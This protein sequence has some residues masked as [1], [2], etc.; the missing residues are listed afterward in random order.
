MGFLFFPLVFMSLQT[1]V[2]F[3]SNL[4]LPSVYF[5]VLAQSKPK[6]FWD[7][8]LWSQYLSREINTRSSVFGGI[9][10]A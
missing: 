2:D 3:L 1:S 5:G 8:L 6:Q 9:R 7:V 4:V 10:F